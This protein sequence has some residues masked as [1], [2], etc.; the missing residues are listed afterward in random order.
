M[1]K[2]EVLLFDYML[3]KISGKLKAFLIVTPSSYSIM[4]GGITAISHFSSVFY[5]IITCVTVLVRLYWQW[6][7]VAVSWLVFL[8]IKHDGIVYFG[9]VG[10]AEMTSGGN[11]LLCLRPLCIHA[12]YR[13][14][15]CTVSAHFHDAIFEH[16]KSERSED[17]WEATFESTVQRCHLSQRVSLPII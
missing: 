16:S 9:A 14:I 3:M 7:R 13:I 10:E 1:G 12:F 8:D 11:D 2:L 6:I 4:E 15:N 17:R 5:A